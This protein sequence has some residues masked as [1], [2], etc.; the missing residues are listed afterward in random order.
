MSNYSTSPIL[1]VTFNRPD[2]AEKVFETIRI[3]RPEKLYFASDGPIIGNPGDEEKITSLR[4]MVLSG[5]NWPC[6]LKTLFRDVNVGLPRAN[7][8]AISW[9]FENEEAGIILEDDTL[10][11]ISFFS[12]CTELL[13]KYEDDERIMHICGLN[14]F[15]HVNDYG[16]SYYFS[17]YGHIW[18]WASWK[19]A[20]EKLDYN[21]LHW[22]KLRSIQMPQ[23]HPFSVMHQNFENVWNGKSKSGL[24][25]WYYSVALNSGLFIIP[26]HSLIKNIGCRS[27]G[28]NFKDGKSPYAFIDRHEIDFPLV[29][30]NYVLINPEYEKSI[31]R[32]KTINKNKSIMQFVKNKTN[33]Y[34]RK[35]IK[36][37]K[38]SQ[39]S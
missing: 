12:F 7:I 3:V 25:R 15:D 17:N 27:D 20:W 18:G 23:D 5:V 28:T 1:F 24:T 19:R 38:T 21:L 29:H 35:I 37:F 26:K 10:P 39:N 9:F 4:N 22:A 14:I 36:G 32:V 11:S 8:Q 30:P 34:G 13:K 6:E 33:Y 16:K 31:I 2:L